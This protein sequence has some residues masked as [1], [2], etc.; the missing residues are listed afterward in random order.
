MAFKAVVDIPRKAGAVWGVLTDVNLW[1]EWWGGAMRNVEPGWEPDGRVKW[2][3][4]STATIATVEEERRLELVSDS[5]GTKWIFELTPAPDGGTRFTFIED[6]TDSRVKVAERD[7]KLAQNEATA[8]K[9]RDAVV[10]RT[11]A[12]KKWWQ[13]WK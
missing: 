8:A 13:F 6:F 10:G 3:R 1:S 4:E 9:F 2:A 5:S 7:A 11:L 12:P